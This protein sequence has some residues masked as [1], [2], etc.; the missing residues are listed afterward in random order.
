MAS[1]L[2]RMAERDPQAVGRPEHLT[3]EQSEA[4]ARRRR[5]R[6]WAM[7][8]VLLG[9]VA[10]FYALTMSRLSEVGDPQRWSRPGAI[11]PSR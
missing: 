11:A 10:L 8:V 1:H 4:I 5:A 6:N 2:A 9:L 7:F 3:R